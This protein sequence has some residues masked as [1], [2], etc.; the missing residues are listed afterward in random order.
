MR[1]QHAGKQRHG[2]M[3]AEVGGQIADAQRA[4]RAL[5]ARPLGGDGGKERLGGAAGA[6]GVIFLVAGPDQRAKG[7]FADVSGHALAGIGGLEF[8]LQPFREHEVAEIGGA[9]E[10]LGQR[11]PLLR[12]RN[13]GLQE[14]RIG[15]LEETETAEHDAGVQHIPEGLAAGGKRSGIGQSF[16]I[17]AGVAVDAAERM[18]KIE[19]VRHMAL[20]TAQGREG[21]LMVTDGEIVGRGAEADLALEIG[22]ELNRASKEGCGAGTVAEALV[23][24]GGQDQRLGIAA[25]LLEKRLNRAQ[26]RLEIALVELPLG[27]IEQCR[28]VFVVPMFRRHG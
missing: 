20:K 5:A 4:G 28:H 17:A 15:L 3:V 24:G 1:L 12:V 18:G 9:P 26:G 22:G 8:G 14:R 10:E 23:D 16:G 13:I 6:A 19:I 21:S 7:I 11:E 25:L 27:L 2:G